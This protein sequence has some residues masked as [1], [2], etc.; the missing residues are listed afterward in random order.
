MLNERSV[1]NMSPKS[2]EQFEAIRQ[3][4]KKSLK[5][6]ALKLFANK[7]FKPT[8]VMDIAK[9]AGVSKGLLYNYYAN[10][11]EL[12]KEIVIKGIEK[13]MSEMNID[14]SQ[15]LTKESFTQMIEVN[16][17]L[18]KENSDY[19]KLYL[20][21]LT[22]PAVTELINNEILEILTPFL[23]AVKGYYEEKGVK[24][25]TAYAYLLGAILDGVGIDYIFAGD[26]YPLDEIKDIIIE[27]FV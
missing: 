3:E 5:A 19:W 2:E 25:P 24:N 21:V 9:D 7:G 22:Q 20:S 18:I 16:F 11:D 6:S 27:K 12:V 10:K 26:V 17:A 1:N 4:R 13:M 23:S 15:K 8:S 14:F